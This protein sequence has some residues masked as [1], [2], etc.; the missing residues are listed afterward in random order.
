MR[1]VYRKQGHIQPGEQQWWLACPG[2]IITDQTKLEPLVTK[3]KGHFLRTLSSSPSIPGEI[4]KAIVTWKLGLPLDE[5]PAN[6]HNQAKDREKEWFIPRSNKENTGDGSKAASPQTAIEVLNY[7]QCIFMRGLEQ[8][9]QGRIG[10][11]VYGVQALVHWNQEGSPHQSILHLGGRLCS[12][13][14]QSSV[15]MD[16]LW[17]TRTL[18]EGCTRCC[19]NFC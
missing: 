2:Q 9:I 15:I 1:F 8:R 17:G 13:R 3:E 12:C 5:C 7:V 6:R 18:P 11:K 14:S 4:G 10:A 19:V 16:I